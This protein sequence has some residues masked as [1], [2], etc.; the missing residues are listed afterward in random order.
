MMID[1]Q[2]T[3]YLNTVPT[4]HR[5]NQ[6]RQPTLYSAL[7]ITEVPW[8]CYQDPK[9]EL[10]TMSIYLYTI[11]FSYSKAPFGLS[12]NSI[13]SHIVLKVL[14]QTLM[15]VSFAGYFLKIVIFASLNVCIFHKPNSFSRTWEN[16]WDLRVAPFYNFL[17]PYISLS[18]TITLKLTNCLWK[19]VIDILTC[20]M[21]KTIE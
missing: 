9:T 1:R 20:G 15:R 18:L 14:L 5:W 16:I 21:P 6:W 12:A 3:V 4:P 19:F 7:N 2:Q 10:I 13:K 11:L 17:W 8:P